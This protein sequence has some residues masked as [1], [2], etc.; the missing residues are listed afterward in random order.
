[1]KS[2]HEY[3]KRVVSQETR[4]KHRQA[5]LGKPQSPETIEKRRQKNLGQTRTVEAKERIRQAKLGK[6]RSEETK[7]KIRQTLTGQKRGAYTVEH[8]A[9]ISA[10]KK[11]KPVTPAMQAAFEAM[12]GVPT[13]RVPWNKGQKLPPISE[14][15]KRRIGEASRGHTLSEEARAR[16]SAARKGKSFAED[17]RAKLSE[18]A[19]Q[20]W[21]RDDTPAFRSKTEIREHLTCLLWCAETPNHIKAIRHRLLAEPFLKF[22]DTLR[23]RSVLL[24]KSDQGLRLLPTH[25]FKKAPVLF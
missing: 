6:P 23:E 4:E 5:K 10:A 25:L 21:A 7:E 9:A 12:R 19:K 15:H 2:P 20:R 3:P 13:G 18:A 8:R 17:H 22:S 1:M 11:G 16:I 24:T 14:E